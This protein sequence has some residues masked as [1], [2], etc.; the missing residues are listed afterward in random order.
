M[1][2]KGV[3]SLIVAT[4]MVTGNLAMAATNDGKVS[5]KNNINKNDI[6]TSPSPVINGIKVNK[7]LI[8]KNF[9]RD[10][11][12]NPKYIVIHD[13]DN[14]AYGAGAIANR[15]YFANHDDA[16]ASAHYIVDDKNI[17]QALEDNWFGW[18]IGDKYK[19]VQ[20][21]VPDAKNNNSIGIE[22]TVNPDSDFDVAMKNAIELVKYL[23]DKHN[24]PADNVIRH[25]D[26]TGKI[27]PRMMIKDRPYLWD[28]FKNA[29]GSKSGTVEVEGQYGV[30]KDEEALVN[31]YEAQ[32]V[33]REMNVAMGVIGQVNKNKKVK[34]NYVKDSWA[35]ITFSN[36]KGKSLTGFTKVY[37]LKI[38]NLEM[39]N[40]TS[41]IV[42][43]GQVSVYK[44][45]DGTPFEYIKSK[46][47][48]RYNYIYKKWANIT[49]TNLEGKVINGFV[50]ASQVKVNES[51]DRG[52]S[53]VS[54]KSAKVINAS[55]VNIREDG[56]IES[57]ILGLVYRNEDVNVNFSKGEWTNVTF[58]AFDGTT[59]TGYMKSEY[60]YINSTTNSNVVNKV[61]NKNDSSTKPV[62]NSGSENISAVENNSLIS[63]GKVTNISSSLRIRSGAGTGYDIL[64]FLSNEETVKIKGKVGGWYKITYNDIEGYVSGDYISATTSTN[65]NI[66]NT[67]P[68]GNSGNKSSNNSSTSNNSNTSSD[69]NT[70]NGSSVTLNKTGE[71][72]NVSTALK[73]RQGAGQEY[74][75]LGWLGLGDK[76]N[77]ISR[78]DKW[79]KINA[80]GIIGFVHSDYLKEVNSNNSISNNNN[81]NNNNNENITLDKG[82]IINVETNLRVRSSMNVSSNIV[83]YLTS[84]QT[85]DILSKSGD[86]YKIR[87]DTYSVKKEGFVQSKYLETFKDTSTTNNKGSKVV[88]EAKKYIGIDYL[89]GGSTPVGFD[90]SGLTSYVYKKF[91]INI[92]RTTWEQIKNGKVVP[93]SGMKEGDL[94]F[95]G[96]SSDPNN[97]THVGIYVGNGSFLHSPKRGEKVTITKL[98]DYKGHIIQANRYI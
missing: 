40:K 87:F 25:N 2:K 53:G 72:I 20:P 23:M 95:F 79:Y 7:M 61:D 38:N 21:N 58:T 35:N 89:W 83:G 55:A 46:T 5:D 96:S 42:A 48:V 75:V 76:V 73:I 82:K 19:G 85:V 49:Y 45:L 27:C 3:A 6:N 44:N 17:V 81:N 29:I 16:D 68:T 67:N 88:Q 4:T 50:L 31:T 28:V 98:S 39:I 65:N 56:N 91:N 12:I 30:V 24:I 92:G 9:Y 84:N 41:E 74:E 86:W 70:S 8:D 33:Y 71:V 34:V 54:G 1:N 62:S 26:A 66:S 78:N 37:N 15:N 90:C 36:E 64:G 63:E 94:I 60:I 13:T 59:K 80:N 93:I 51:L 22:I 10:L 77:V 97:P 11:K 47:K 14:R 69:K 57:S 43:N 18:H 32:D 52:D